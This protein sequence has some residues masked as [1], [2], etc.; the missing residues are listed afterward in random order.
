MR[1]LDPFIGWML[2]ACRL[3]PAAV[4]C[5]VTVAASGQTV[6]CKADLDGSGVVDAAD[7]GALLLRFGESGGPADLDGSAS[8]DA[9]DLGAILVSFGPCVGPAWGTV[10]EWAPS[11]SVITDSGLRARIQDTHLPWRVRDNGTGI[12]MVLIPSGVY[13]RGCTRSNSFPCDASESPTHAVTLTGAFYLGRTEV[14]QAQWVAKM[15]L[16]PSY[17]QGSS[18]PSAASRPVEQVSWND[19]AIFRSATGLRLPTEAEWEYA[20]RAGTITAFHGWPAVPAGTNDDNQLASIAWFY[21]G[22]CSTGAQCQTRMVAGKAANGFGLFDMAGNV[23]EWCGDWYGTYASGTQTN[24]AGPASGT[25]RVIRGGGWGVGWDSCR[26]STRN[27]LTPDTRSIYAGF[28]V[29][30][31]P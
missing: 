5:T 3:V 30:R 7:I 1:H 13:Q 29:A 14:T 24:P 21:T 20:C 11:S 12:E 31:N 28:R 9:A 8:V 27:G 26:S 22:T 25:F 23:W 18:W 6:P 10:L 19:I 15:G 17:F 16:N 4:A 2:R